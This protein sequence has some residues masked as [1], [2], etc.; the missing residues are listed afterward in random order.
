MI[1]LILIAIGLGTLWWSAY[2]DWQNRAVPN[3]VWIM[4]LAVAG[5]FLALELFLTPSTMLVRLASLAGLAIVAWL[6]WVGRQLGGADAKA[7]LVLAILITPYWNPS[8]A[9]MVPVLDALPVALIVGE[10]YR[11]WRGQASIPFLVALAPILSLT[12]A[13]GGLL[14]WPIVL[15]IRLAV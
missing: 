11:R 1:S 14:W 7:I 3:H 8:E 13:I 9:R 5:P 4:A 6:L 15:L 10:G 12:A 2:L